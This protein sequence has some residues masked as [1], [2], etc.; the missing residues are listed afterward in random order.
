MEHRQEAGIHSYNY[1]QVLRSR[2]FYEQHSTARSLTH[3]M[4]QPAYAKPTDG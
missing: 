2:C 3:A 4:L 1:S